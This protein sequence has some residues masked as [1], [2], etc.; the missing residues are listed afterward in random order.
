MR[1]SNQF[2]TP[3][4]ALFPAKKSKGGFWFLGANL[5]LEGQTMDRYL[6]IGH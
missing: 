3:R 5:V 6:E 2:L 1:V 4:A